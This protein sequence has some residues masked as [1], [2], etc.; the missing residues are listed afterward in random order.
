MREVETASGLGN[1]KSLTLRVRHRKKKKKIQFLVLE[2]RKL[3]RG[4]EDERDGGAFGDPLRQT[5]K[6]LRPSG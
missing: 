2:E 5:P 3:P 4:G 6:C 1:E